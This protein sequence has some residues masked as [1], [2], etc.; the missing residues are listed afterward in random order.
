MK[1]RKEKP[2]SSKFSPNAFALDQIL[3]KGKILA[4]GESPPEMVER[5]VSALHATEL[6]LSDNVK[7]LRFAE[8]IGEL[9][10]EGKIV[11]ST[12]VMTNAGRS[13]FNRPLSACVVPPL[14]LRGDIS[15]VRAMVTAYHEEAMGTG[16]N[17]DEVDDPVESLLFLNDV[18]INGAKSGKEDRPV[19]NMGVCSVD[20]PRIA[21]FITSKMI[22]RD[23]LWKFNI[24]INTPES[25]WCAVNNDGLWRLRNGEMVYAKELLNLMVQSAHACADPGL[26]FMDRINRDN[27]VPGSGMYHGVA[28][29]GEVGLA[30][31]ETCQFAYI[32]LG[33][34]SLNNGFDLNGIKRAT[35]L[36]VRALDD[37]LEISI[38]VYSVQASAEIT[39]QRRKIGIGV[40]GLADALI[41]QGIPYA[42]NIARECARNVVAFINYTSKKASHE[43]AKERGSFSAMNALFGCRYTTN[44]N[45]LQVKYGDIDTKWVSGKEWKNLGE[46]IKSSKM[47]RNSSTT[48]LPPTGRCALIVGASPGI[49]PI[50]SHTDLSGAT[51]SS[52]KKALHPLMGKINKYASLKAGSV[53]KWLD[54]DLRELLRTS[55]EIDPKDHLFMAAALQQVVDE[56][57]SKT[58]NLPQSATVAQVE[59][60]YTWAYSLN[61]K[62]MTLYRDGTSCFQ[63]RKL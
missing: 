47:L 58:V 12:P 54:F 44:P 49:E 63:P 36:L 40:C 7:A 39:R 26:I 22:R 23:M 41:N 51:L 62:G 4:K 19:G 45:F 61:L 50:F 25:F 21:E 46:L 53:E 30:L 17:L 5:V 37:C 10:D 8:S 33:A 59:Q 32:N 56:S 9:M 18:A 48:A 16:F 28:P 52:V 38:P 6:A 3:K 55:A 60:I 31:G 34:F 24:S 11:F 43:L 42:S 20:H 15:K 27:P 35:E 14:S 57:I 13:D 1:N 29:C 2:Y